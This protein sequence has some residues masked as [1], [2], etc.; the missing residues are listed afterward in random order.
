MSGSLLTERQI[1]KT[2]KDFGK[3]L[4]FGKMILNDIYSAIRRMLVGDGTHFHADVFLFTS[5][6]S[7]ALSR[8][9]Y[10]GVS[11]KKFYEQAIA[12]FQNKKEGCLVGQFCDSDTNLFCRLKCRVF[13][14]ANNIFERV[15]LQKCLSYQA[16]KCDSIYHL[17]FACSMESPNAP[18]RCCICLA[19]V[20][21]KR[22]ISGASP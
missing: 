15:L 18:C 20:F 11:L 6:S 17:N 14:G 10:E 12:S 19:A 2:L 4:Y 21:H 7:N 1:N 9:F 5:S 16:M 8:G 13:Q 3:V 22:W